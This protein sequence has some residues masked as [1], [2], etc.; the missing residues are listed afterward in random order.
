MDRTEYLNRLLRARYAEAHDLPI[1]PE[2][3]LEYRGIRWYPY[4]YIMGSDGNGNY[5]H[6]AVLHDLHANSTAR[7]DLKEIFETKEI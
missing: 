6:T 5:T 3:I 2:C 7:A 4:E 1:P